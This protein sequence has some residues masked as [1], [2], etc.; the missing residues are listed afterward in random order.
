ME[1]AQRV[2]DITAAEGRTGKKDVG[3]HSERQVGKSVWLES[4]QRN[5]SLNKISRWMQGTLKGNK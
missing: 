1:I 4:R 5:R 2:V 3:E